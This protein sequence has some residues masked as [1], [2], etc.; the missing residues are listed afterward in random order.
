[1]EENNLMSA[2]QAFGNVTPADYRILTEP[3]VEREEFVR[4]HDGITHKG[5]GGFCHIVYLV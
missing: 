3:S 5:A 2:P 4:T 1:M